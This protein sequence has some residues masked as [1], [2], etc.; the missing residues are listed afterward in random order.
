MEF[1]AKMGSDI[2]LGLMGAGLGSFGGPAAPLTIPLGAAAGQYASDTL[3]GT[4][5]T[6]RN[7]NAALAFAAPVAAESLAVGA[8][9]T[10]GVS[11]GTI[12]DTINEAYQSPLET[13]GGLRTTR[14]IAG[15]PREAEM[16]LADKIDTQLMAEER[17]PFLPISRSQATTVEVI[18][19]QYRGVAH[20]N[21]THL[22]Q[23][24]ANA[25]TGGKT[26]FTAEKSAAQTAMQP[27][28]DKIDT[29]A[30]ARGGYVDL[31]DVE[32][33]LDQLREPTNFAVEGGSA[34][35]LAYKSAQGQVDDLIRKE[36]TD[37][38]DLKLYNDTKSAMKARLDARDALRA[39]VGRLVPEAG[40]ENFYKGMNAFIRRINQPTAA[41]DVANKILKNYDATHAT[42]WFKQSKRL[43][44]AR[45][46]SPDD[47]VVAKGLWAALRAA[48]AIAGTPVTKAATELSIAAPAIGPPVREYIR[49]NYDEQ[50]PGE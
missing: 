48:T 24:F 31:T 5:N 34:R 49:S 10:S 39:E 1:M 3:F 45:Q 18:L 20:L 13:A 43:N 38:D 22:K 7:I 26:A 42:D 35:T 32:E 36:I 30:R 28:I 47:R 44:M 6:E 9:L 23:I 50:P 16:H 17:G 15:L 8:G 14:P 37:P 19:D 25:A 29:I 41:G 11:R 2:G 33:L 21:P 12:R 40:E 46:W 4:P 27:I